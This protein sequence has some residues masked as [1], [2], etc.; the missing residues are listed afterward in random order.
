MAYFSNT[1]SKAERNNCVTRRQLVAVVKTLEH[2]HKYLYGQESHLRTD[3]STLNWRLSFRN[4]EGQTARWVRR[5]QEDSFS[6]EH[7]QMRKHTK[8]DAFPWKPCSEECACC[9]KVEGQAA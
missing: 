4:L 2:F 5:L 6:S 8:A 3:Q 1:L 9:Q 7:R